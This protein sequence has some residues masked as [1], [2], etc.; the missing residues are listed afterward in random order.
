[1]RQ[2]LVN[3]VGNA[4]KFTKTGAVVV[5]VNLGQETTDD[6]LP[7]FEV[8]DT[9]IGISHEV[10]STLFDA[11]AQA[12][13]TTTRQYGGTGLG[14]T[15]SK[16]LV[17]LMGG[18]IGCWSEPGQGSTFWFTIASAKRPAFQNEE[19]E[20]PA[21]LRAV[22][23]LYIDSAEAYRLI[24]ET[25]LQDWGMHVDSATDATHGLARLRAAQGTQHPYQLVILHHL[26]DL[27]G[28][29][30]AQ[31][32]NAD[33]GI[34][35]VAI[36]LLNAADNREHKQA[37]KQAGIAAYWVKPIRRS[38]MQASLVSLL[39]NTT[40]RPDT[41]GDTSSESP[42]T[43]VEPPSDQGPRVLVAEDNVVNQRVAEHLLEKLGCNVDVVDNGRKAVE[44]SARTAYACIFMDCQ[45]P[46]MDG[47]E[48][49]AAIRE[50]EQ[51]SGGHIPII[52]LTAHVMQ[53]ERGRCFT[54]GMDH[55]LSKPLQVAA[56]QAVLQRCLSQEL[57]DFP[58]RDS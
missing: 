10:Q 36:V 55:Y 18:E 52:A 5:H 54:V 57:L 19:P 1:L 28:I 56:L 24:L 51:R 58:M 13:S 7:R 8:T 27:D 2:T 17:E 35:P 48:A 43:S 39:V 6:I 41:P 37:A 30:V 23:V 31:A 49:T 47:F 22:R 44:A 15:I 29:A 32:I 42:V 50:R 40:A 45:M 4:I 46:D 21:V 9:G 11:F 34:P 38:H 14:L 3:L 16:S 53:E 26:P 33:P 20:A 25:Q 12:D